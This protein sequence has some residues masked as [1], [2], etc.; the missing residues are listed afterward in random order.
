MYINNWKNQKY[1][2]FIFGSSTAL[3]VT[4]STWKTCLDTSSRV[5]SFDASRENIIGIWSK[6]KFIDRN[7]QPI[8]NALL[9]I[10]YDKA[11]SRLE[12]DNV[13]FTKHYRVYRSSWIDFQ[14]K[15]FLNFLNPFFLRALITYQI[16]SEF[17]P[18]MSEFLID[19]TSFI[20]PVT[21][22]FHSISVTEE[23]KTDSIN[24]YETRKLRFPSR[25]ST[26]CEYKS[27][28]ND[29]H[30]RM[31]KEMKEIFDR[32]KTQFRIIIAP[33]Y[34]EIY[35]NRTDLEFLNSVFGK[36]NVF[37]FTGVNRFSEDMSNFYDGLH[38]KTYVGRQL[39]EIAYSLIKQN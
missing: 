34:E 10:D 16:T 1:N 31:L 28:I 39:L 29:D 27:Q 21:N 23:L 36:E 32:N 22:E 24:Y 15:N 12:K 6:I 20:D 3:F 5:F 37:D 7:K 13:L 2:S 35:F 11:F 18:Y 30:V 19:E 33:N 9:V 14:I 17:K 38:F 8:K 4:P 26:F 25:K